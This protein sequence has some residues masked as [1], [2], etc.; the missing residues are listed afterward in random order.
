MKK[1]EFQAVVF[2]GDGHS[3]TSL[4]TNIHKAFLPIANKPMIFHVFQWLEGQGLSGKEFK[5]E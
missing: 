3:L 5:E 2:A 4:T 1:P